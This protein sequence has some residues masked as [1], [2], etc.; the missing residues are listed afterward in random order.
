MG[1]NILEVNNIETYYDHVRALH[2]VSF[3]IEEGSITTVL[4]NNGAG[5]TTTL[6]TIMGLLDDQPDL[7][8]VQHRLMMAQVL[9]AV[10]ALEDGVLTDIRTRDCATSLPR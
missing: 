2:G 9:E 3:E 8:E 5:K 10:R 1:K 7:T 4:G 6:N